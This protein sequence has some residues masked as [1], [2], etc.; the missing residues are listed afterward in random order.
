MT[1]ST[2]LIQHKAAEPAITIFVM[3]T[4]P[5][6]QF[7]SVDPIAIGAEESTEQQS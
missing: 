3:K 4:E 1:S 6:E 2:D 7:H 5:L